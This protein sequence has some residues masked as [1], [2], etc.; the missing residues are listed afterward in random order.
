MWAVRY[1][2]PGFEREDNVDKIFT[3]SDKFEIS[4]KDLFSVSARVM[5]YTSTVIAEHQ[6]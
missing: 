2:D 1:P 5:K 6:Q 4:A 3:I